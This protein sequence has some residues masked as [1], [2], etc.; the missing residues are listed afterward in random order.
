MIA[1]SCPLSASSLTLAANSP[2]TMSCPIQYSTFVRSASAT[3][4]G[5]DS[6]SNA[7]LGSKPRGNKTTSW[8]VASS[9][10]S[11]DAAGTTHPTAHVRH[12]ASAQQK[13]RLNELIPPCAE[14]QAVAKVTKRTGNDLLRLVGICE[15]MRSEL[16]VETDKSQTAKQHIRDDDER[17]TSAV[18]SQSSHRRAIDTIA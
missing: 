1:A 5:A 7:S 6:I 13:S 15:G 2:V 4:R 17:S 8:L 12:F 9:R 11:R 3:T 14:P 16:Y 18:T 10:S